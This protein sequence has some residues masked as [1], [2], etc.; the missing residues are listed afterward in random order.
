[1]AVKFRRRRRPWTICHETKTIIIFYRCQKVNRTRAHR[2][3]AENVI[4]TVVHAKLSYVCIYNN[5]MYLV[6]NNTVTL[7][8]LPF[9]VIPGPYD[10]RAPII[11]LHGPYAIMYGNHCVPAPFSVTRR[12]RV[13]HSREFVW[14]SILRLGQIRT[15]KLE[16]PWVTAIYNTFLRIVA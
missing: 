5:L 7:F 10:T 12:R 11:Y 6:R 16:R 4:I 3:C 1:M 9:R 15:S 13:S 14:Q 8:F 2:T